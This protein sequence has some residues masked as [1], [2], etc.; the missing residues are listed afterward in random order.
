MKLLEKI[1]N[2]IRK[3]FLNGEVYYINGSETLLPPL[4]KDEE[5]MLLEKSN[6]G[7][8]EARNKLIEHN[9]RLVAHIAKKYENT[10][11]DK[12]ELLARLLRYDKLCEIVSPQSYRNELKAMLNK[13]LENY[14][15]QNAFI[16]WYR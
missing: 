1:K 5:I 16:N 3:Y 15:E 8:L 14:E 4:D 6:N 10:G 9:L 13:M 11:E 2:I 7:D 12:D